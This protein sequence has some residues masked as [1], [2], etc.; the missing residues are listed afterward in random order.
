MS[1]LILLSTKY[2][3]K[4]SMCNFINTIN[5]LELCSLKINT[6]GHKQLSK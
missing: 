2:K 1:Y 6:C 3:Q 5:V 4:C